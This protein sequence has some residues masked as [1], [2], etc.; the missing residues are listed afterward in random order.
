MDGI[1]ECPICLQEVNEFQFNSGKDSTTTIDCVRCGRFRADGEFTRGIFANPLENRHLYS[2]AIREINERGVEIAQVTDL[3]SFLYQVKVPSNPLEMMDRFLLSI[4]N[5]LKR[6]DEHLFLTE[7]DYPLAYSHDLNEWSWI[8]NQMAEMRLIEPWSGDYQFRILPE[9][10]R[11]LTELS[12]TIRRTDQAFV[13]MSFN[14]ILDVLFNDGIK[15]A[16]IETG[17]SPFRVDRNEHNEKIDDLIVAE[18][19]RS[20][21]VIADFTQHRNGVYF[22]AGFGLGLGLPVIWICKDDKDEIDNLHFDTRQY[23]H[24]MWKDPA[25]LKARLIN[26]INATAPAPKKS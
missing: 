11:R 4:R 3:D 10:W 2:G 18:I 26:R 24:I 13:A 1:S 21:I 23:N 12:K 6:A 25:D 15:P 14:P 17:Y 22:E 5:Q 20:G 19:R 7:Y 8:Y 9:G 16:L